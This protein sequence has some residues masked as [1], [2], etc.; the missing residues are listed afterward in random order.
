MKIYLDE[1][2]ELAKMADKIMLEYLTDEKGD[3]IHS[4]IGA[5]DN[6]MWWIAGVKSDTAKEYWYKQFQGCTHPNRHLVGGIMWC[7]DCNRDVY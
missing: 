7:P 1:E 2:Q 3:F 6:K 5:D 4:T